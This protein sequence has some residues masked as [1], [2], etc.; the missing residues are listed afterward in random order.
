MVEVQKQGRA[1]EASREG[2][3]REWLSG[4]RI[5]GGDR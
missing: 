2:P 1:A 4:E 5:L 3:G